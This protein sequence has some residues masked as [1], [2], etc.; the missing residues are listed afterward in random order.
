MIPIS[1]CDKVFGGDLKT[2]NNIILNK[3]DIVDN[4]KDKI[5]TL[6]T[7]EVEYLI[8]VLFSFSDKKTILTK[9]LIIIILRPKH[10]GSTVNGLPDTIS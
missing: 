9:K 2:T 6:N 1:S 8:L 10:S 5:I 7:V 3:F 4:R